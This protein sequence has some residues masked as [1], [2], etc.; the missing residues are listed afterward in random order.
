MPTYI[1]ARDLKDAFPNLDEFDTKKPVYG[2]VAE[3]TK[4]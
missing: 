2:R 4:R 3:S 1:T